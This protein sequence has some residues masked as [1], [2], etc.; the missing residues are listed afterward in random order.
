MLEL[1]TKPCYINL[2]SKPKVNERR[3]NRKKRPFKEVELSEDSESE[4][5]FDWETTV[6]TVNKRHLNKRQGMNKRHFTEGFNGRALGRKILIL[7]M[8][9]KVFFSSF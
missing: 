2:K 8:T 7:K 1:K 5:E 9:R 6:K 3:L 4:T